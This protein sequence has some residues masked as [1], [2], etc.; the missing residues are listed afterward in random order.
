[1]KKNN[2]SPREKAELDKMWPKAEEYII[3]ARPE[4]MSMEEYKVRRKHGREMG[5][6]RSKFYGF[7]PVTKN[8]K[9]K[10][11]TPDSKGSPKGRK[12]DKQPDIP[13]K[14]QTGD[15]DGEGTTVKE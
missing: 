11:E 10:K 3:G 15:K 7:E 9:I 2:L 1:M 5:K 4:G 14:E 8:G 6:F 12:E 13:L